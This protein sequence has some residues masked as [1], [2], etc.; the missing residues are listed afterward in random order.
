[1]ERNYVTVTVCIVKIAQR[2][3]ILC[4]AFST[5]RKTRITGVLKFR[6]VIYSSEY[7]F[8]RRRRC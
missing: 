4:Y 6:L 5:A 3:I 1:M 7:K 8:T 2:L